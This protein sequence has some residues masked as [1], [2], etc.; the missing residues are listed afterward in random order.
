[1]NKLPD[2]TGTTG[3]NYFMNAGK[4]TLIIVAVLVLIVG[5]VSWLLVNNLDRIAKSTV[6]EAGRKLLETEVSVDSVDITVLKGKAGL[7]GLVI[8][9]PAGY[10][11]VPALT[12]G[13]IEVD[14][15]LT[16][17]DDDV[18]VIEN[19]LIQDPV[20]NYEVDEDG[21]AIIDA[22]QKSIENSAPSK[23]TD[24][25]L[26]IIE[27]IDFKGGTITATAPNQTD[28]KLEF[29]FPVVFMSD[30]GRPDGATPEQIGAEITGVLMER[31]LSAAKRAGVDALVSEQTDRLRE[32]ADEKIQ[33]K[34][35]KLLKRD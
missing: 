4:I 14:I 33:E 17:A 26:M 23:G 25:G 22:L 8:A 12:L 1:M 35:D 16:S 13:R 31:I 9:T 27:R 15:D 29:D 18:L 5:V 30:L 2:L 34:L 6:E 19:I 21:K 11:D 28:Q 3:N 20:V 10:S 32:A 24:N 7:S